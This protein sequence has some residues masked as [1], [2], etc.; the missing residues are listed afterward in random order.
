MWEEDGDVAVDGG[1]GV[2]LKNALLEMGAGA[3]DV[4]EGIIGGFVSGE[5][6]GKGGQTRGEGEEE[7]GVEGVRVFFGLPSPI[8]RPAVV[9]I[10]DKNVGQVTVPSVAF[11]TMMGSLWRSRARTRGR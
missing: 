9:F 1:G 8:R 7:R 3:E 11:S 5:V 6:E 2:T 4:K 10:V